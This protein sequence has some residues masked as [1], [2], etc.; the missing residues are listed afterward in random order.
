MRK[1]E[2]TP[3][4]SKRTFTLRVKDEKGN[5]ISKYRTYKMSANEFDDYEYYTKT[6]WDYF[7]KTNHYIVL[8]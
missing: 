5:V 1:I 8:K 3:N 4:K 6:D 7:L 2:A